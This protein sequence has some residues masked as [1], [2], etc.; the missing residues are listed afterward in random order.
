MS[1]I[2]NLRNGAKVIDDAEVDV[3]AEEVRDGKAPVDDCNTLELMN[4]NLCEQLVDKFGTRVMDDLGAIVESL[5]S[6]LLAEFKKRDERFLNL[7]SEV[8][9]LR[10]SM[11]I[12]A[13]KLAALEAKVASL[14]ANPDIIV[15]PPPPSS[16]SPFY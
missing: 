16:S 12:S 7:E 4:R 6:D 13:V 10:D 2:H 5:K 11:A 9:C 8:I 1:R 15:T 14:S 3:F